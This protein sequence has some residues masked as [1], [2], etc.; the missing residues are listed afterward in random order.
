MSELNVTITE[1]NVTIRPAQVI[2]NIDTVVVEQSIMDWKNKRLL[3]RL[4]DFPGHVVLAAGA[5]F[6]ALPD[7]PYVEA[8]LEGQ[9]RAVF[10]NIPDVPMV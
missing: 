2:E 7:K 10:N 6:D 8:S 3:V 1:R 4:K 9:V 5:E